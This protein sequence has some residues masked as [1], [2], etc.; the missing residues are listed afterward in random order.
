MIIDYTYDKKND[1]YELSFETTL[2]GH[3]QIL[4][5]DDLYVEWL[6]SKGMMVEHGSGTFDEENLTSDQIEEIKSLVML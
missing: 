1:R 2:V 4:H 5:L 3:Y 6:I